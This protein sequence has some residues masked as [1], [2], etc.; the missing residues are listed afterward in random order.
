MYVIMYVYVWIVNSK[1]G[2]SLQA[3]LV[4]WHKSRS[5]LTKGRYEAI[6]KSLAIMCATDLRPTSIVNGA[7]FKAF[8]KQLNPEYQVPCKETVTKYL[9]LAYKETK[10]DVMSQLNGNSVGITTDLWTSLTQMS[11][12]TITGHYITPQWQLKSNILAT[13]VMRDHHTAVHISQQLSLIAEEFDIQVSGIVTDNARNMVNAAEVSHYERVSCF[14]HTLQLAVNDG[15]KH[16]SVSKALGAGRRLVGHFS[17][18][19]LATES[20]LQHQVQFDKTSK[21]VKLIQDVQTRWNSSFLMMQ[22]LLKLRVPVYAVIM[23]DKVTKQSDRSDL[24]IPDSMWRTMEDITP[25]LAPLAQATEILANESVPTISS[26]YVLLPTLLAGLSD[27]EG[28]SMVV[29]DVKKKIRTS[30]STRMDIDLG[31][32][33]SDKT[34][35]SLPLIATFLDPR[36][37]TLKLM[38]PSK[39]E[40]VH[41]T[42]IK[43]MSEVEGSSEGT[44]NPGVTIKKEASIPKLESILFDCLK[45]D[46]VDLTEDNSPNSPNSYEHEL[47]LY[48]VEQVRIPDPLL[49]WKEQENKFPYLAKLAKKVLAIP[50][51]EVPSERAFSVAGLTVTKLRSSLDPQ[52]VDNIL[53]LHKNYVH[54]STLDANPI[55]TSTVT[56]TTVTPESHSTPTPSAGINSQATTSGGNQIKKEAPQLPS[57]ELPSDIM[58]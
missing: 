30:L 13:R 12:I 32:V 26:I 14:A 41:D 51:T 1:L 53:F 7:G 3:S 27:I 19:S 22:R 16:A 58:E 23:D 52:N 29:Q 6:N 50:A 18:S 49:W 47:E 37:K 33:P 48:I 21:P 20:L 39:R 38:P 55:K 5:A 42:V 31:G 44:S 43:M 28:D 15:L 35:T 45:G 46:I 56:S 8:V 10:A 9:N 4:N 24:D 11:Y 34:L 2:P 40:I 54:H 25:V 36:Y 17:H 57:L